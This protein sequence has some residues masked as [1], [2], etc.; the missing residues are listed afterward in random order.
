[1][2][3]CTVT[4]QNRVEE[5]VGAV[6]SGPRWNI[7]QLLERGDLCRLPHSRTALSDVTLRGL[8]LKDQDCAASYVK[9]EKAKLTEAEEGSGGQG[10]GA[11]GQGEAGRGAHV[12]LWVSSGGPTS[13]TGTAG[14]GTAL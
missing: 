4:K 1:M 3:L 12:Q 10:L 9:S 13:G 11:G 6:P 14:T 2:C 7:T 5:N 8:S